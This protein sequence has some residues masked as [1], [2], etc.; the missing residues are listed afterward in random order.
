MKTL[1]GKFFLNSEK[2]INFLCVL[3]FKVHQKRFQNAQLEFS[4]R[5]EMQTLEKVPETVAKKP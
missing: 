3:S 4:R 1:V 2:E 5:L